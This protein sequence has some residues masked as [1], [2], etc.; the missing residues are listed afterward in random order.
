[1]LLFTQLTDL[2]CHKETYLDDQ[3]HSADAKR[4]QLLEIRRALD[5][6]GAATIRFQYLKGAL[7][8]STCLPLDK[9]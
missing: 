4:T 1:M 3:I 9:R 8:V 6:V 2:S 5:T 7:N